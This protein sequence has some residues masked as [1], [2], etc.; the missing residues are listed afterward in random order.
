ML[1]PGGFKQQSYES[2]QPFYSPN[3][4][5]TVGSYDNTL[6]GPQ[7]LS[8]QARTKFRCEMSMGISTAQARTKC[9]P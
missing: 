5:F 2:N 1:A 9:G 3:S 8:A 6:C 4:V 7:R